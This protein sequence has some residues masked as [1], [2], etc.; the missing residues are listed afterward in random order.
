M[1]N[2]CPC[3]HKVCSR[4][5]VWKMPC[6]E[7]HLISY[8]HHQGQLHFGNDLDALE[9]S[10]V[11][12]LLSSAPAWPRFTLGRRA[13]QSSLLSDWTERVHEHTHTRTHSHTHTHTGLNST[14]E[15]KG[16]AIKH[17]PFNEVTDRG[18]H[19][20]TYLQ[21]QPVTGVSWWGFIQLAHLVNNTG[22]LFN[23]SSRQI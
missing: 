22:K 19:T 12:H 6:V 7:K 14:Q 10:L 3:S 8:H 4:V 23:K 17:C 1:Q 18:R 11:P 5:P 13:Q 2:S 15:T 16:T 21:T 9:F 20:K